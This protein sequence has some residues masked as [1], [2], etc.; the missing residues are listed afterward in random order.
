DCSSEAPA[1]TIHHFIDYYRGTVLGFANAP[2]AP[3]LPKAADALRALTADPTA[4]FS[5]N[6]HLFSI[7]PGTEHATIT[8]ANF[9]IGPVPVTLEVYSELH[10]GVDVTANF[11]FD[12]GGFL[13]DTLLNPNPTDS[14]YQ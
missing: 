2:Q 10:Y 4:R 14:P 7:P 5:N 12:P 11:S 6:F 8:S 1:T 9:F 3:S 13:A